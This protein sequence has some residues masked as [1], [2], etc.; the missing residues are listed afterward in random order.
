MNSPQGWGDLLKIFLQTLRTSSSIICVE[1]LRPGHIIIAANLCGPPPVP[2][3]IYGGTGT[4]MM[5]IARQGFPM[6][7]YWQK[8]FHTRERH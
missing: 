6:T 5:H 1:F 2:S 8:Q 7:I 4:F 3:N